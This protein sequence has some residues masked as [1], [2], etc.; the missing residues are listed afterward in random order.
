MLSRWK[1]YYLIKRSG[2]FDPSYYLFNYP[3]VRKADVN[4]L[5]H[6]I[7][8]GWKE[9]RNPSPNF[10]TKYY[11]NKNPDVI[12]AGI[13][14]LLYYV[15]FGKKEGHKANNDNEYS[16]YLRKCDNNANNQYVKQNLS[17]ERIIYKIIKFIFRHLPLTNTIRGKIKKYFRKKLLPLLVDNSKNK[18]TDD[19]ENY[20]MP[21]RRKALESCLSY[22]NCKS[23]NSAN[24]NYFFTLPF[25]STGGAELVMM[26]FI[27][28]KLDTKKE[29]NALIV[30]SDKN[31]IDTNL[32]MPTNA[33]V[34][35]LPD[36]LPTLDI[37]ER[38][39][40]TYDLINTIKPSLIHNINSD[41]MWNLIIEKG[42]RLRKYSKIYANIF[43]FQYDSV[44]N[45][46]G[47]AE[48]YLR[49]ALP[50]LDGVI[51]DNKRF[52]SDAIKDYNLQSQA[53]K[54]FTVYTPT[55]VINNK[56]VSFTKSQ[57]KTYSDRIKCTPKI[58]CV[59]AG[60]MDVEKRLDLFFEVVK[61]CDFADFDMFGHSVVDN[62][63]ILPELPNLSY[64]GGF[65]TTDELFLKNEYCAFI[66]TSKWEGMPNI[67]IEAGCWGIPIIAPVVGGIGEL[68][69][70]DTGYPLPEN[71][72][73]V[74]YVNA[75]KEI[76]DEPEEAARRANNMLELIINRHNWENF[77]R[78]VNRV[79][80]Y[81]G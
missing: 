35:N 33:I 44:G 1:E 57:L 2:L 51:S 75:L 48:Y 14:P 13:N 80:G 65:R 20:R 34:L 17:Q 31:K 70:H 68:V 63:L 41:V 52:I 30:I 50:Y 9:G 12:E 19:F 78:S 37:K 61:H 38:E 15:K 73:C 49:S 45:K 62:N 56:V 40:L 3:D 76:I 47:Y 4:P 74:D 16:K 69:N 55:R 11:V 5:R 6:F 66:F 7:T 54:L 72:V 43:A 39:I 67:L 32:K 58:K 27:H 22:L 10:I 59:W 64:R 71:P 24:L 36:L 46:V 77:V 25:L 18:V 79:I 23:C 53:H 8:A 28:L 81:I 42:E 60:R 21:W 26:N 29:A